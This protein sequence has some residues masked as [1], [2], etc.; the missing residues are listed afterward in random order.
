MGASNSKKPNQLLTTILWLI[1]KP[2]LKFTYNFKFNNDVIKG[3][4]GPAVF[5]GNHAS[6]LDVF[7]MGV[8]AYP[9]SLNYV[10]GYDWFTYLGLR[11]IL[12]HLKAIPKFQYQVDLGSIKEMIEV[13][14]QNQI[15]G[16][17]PT[18]RLASA[19]VGL[20]VDVNVA[21]LIKKLKAPVYFFRIDGAYLSRP[22]WAKKSRKGKIEGKYYQLFTSAQLIKKD[23]KEITNIINQFMLYDDYAWNKQK[24]IL[25]KGKCLA[26]NLEK[27]LFLCPSCNQE[28]NL[29]SNNNI[30]SCRCG[31]KNKVLESGFFE[32]RT[33]FESPKDWN[34][35]QKLTLK[36]QIIKKEV[37]L[38]SSA[39]V[40]S[41]TTKDKN[42]E[43]FGEGY[44]TFIDDQLIFKGKNNSET[45]ELSIK[46]KD[47]PSLPFKAGHNFEISQ[48][49]F[50]YKFVLKN[51]N[52][53][54]KWSLIVEALHE[55][56]NHGK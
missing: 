15:L 41:S 30:I 49:Q 47:F 8:S 52:E 18:G 16:I 27:V 11:F 37:S 29:S 3:I 43:L 28:F 39:L 6:V 1:F 14:N 25:Y 33:H 10:A 23:T 9:K 35:F 12:K 2:Y 48:D 45:R 20:P 21:K 7:L 13:I 40:Y 26:E 38:L 54:A 36:E 51:G 46:L 53:A 44:L 50:I 34:K 5:I 31:Y 32:D 56:N 19:G 55:V 22:K 24:A 4:K 42:K 17:F